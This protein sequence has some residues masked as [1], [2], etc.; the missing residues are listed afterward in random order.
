MANEN[1]PQENVLDDNYREEINWD[2]VGGVPAQGNYEF[3]VVK[4]DPVKSK[5]SGKPMLKVQLEIR[6]AYEEANAEFVKRMV[7]ENLMLTAADGFR[8]KEFCEAAGVEPP[9]VI[10]RETVEEFAHFLTGK[11]LGGAIRHRVY[12]GRTQANVGTYFAE[13]Q[14]LVPGQGQAPQQ[15]EEEAP[16]PKRGSRSNGTNSARQAAAP[17]QGPTRSLRES[18]PQRGTTGPKNGAAN[19]TTRRR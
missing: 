5:E 15:Q 3:I 10:S 1:Y 11:T 13:G 6:S 8:T 17:H 18:V 2:K 9:S 14:P 19:G 12:Q 4:A 7:F 16:T